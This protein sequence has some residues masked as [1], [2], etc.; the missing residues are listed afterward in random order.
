MEHGHGKPQAAQSRPAR[1]GPGQPASSRIARPH[2]T[3]G[4]APPIANLAAD[5]R[6]AVAALDAGRVV[7]GLDARDAQAQASK[8]PQ[9]TKPRPIDAAPFRRR[10]PEARA[11]LGRPGRRGDNAEADAGGDR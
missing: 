9:R 6:V 3:A 2:G 11:S 4:V 7:T 8:R 1:T 10:P 5:G